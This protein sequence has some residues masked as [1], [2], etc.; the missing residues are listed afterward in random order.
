[1]NL[2][3]VKEFQ[4]HNIGPVSFDVKAGEIM[5]LSGPSGSGK[6]LLLRALADMDESSGSVMLDD[7]EKNQLPAPQWRQKVSLLSADSQWWF[8]TV[9]EHFDLQK[10]KSLMAEFEALGFPAEVLGWTVSRLSS[11]EKQRLSLLRSLQN[12]PEV[13]LL[14][15][16]TANLDAENTRLF[17]DYVKHYI[18][19][20]SAGAI[21]V[22][23]DREQLKRVCHIQ[24]CINHGQFEKC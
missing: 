9:G 17:E 10:N 19:K 15:E 18:H 1:M 22:S 3:S 13:L 16:P 5:G 2:F 8:D 4:Y 21:W 11:G 14:D 7:I 12:Q 23:H 24:Y 6:S 20:A